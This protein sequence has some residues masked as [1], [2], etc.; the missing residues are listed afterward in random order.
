[1]PQ[2]SH[3]GIINTLRDSLEE[4]SGQAIWPLKDKL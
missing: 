1:M 3:R 4:K 2:A